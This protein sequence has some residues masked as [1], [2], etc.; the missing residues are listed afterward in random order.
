MKL[1]PYEK[2][3]I[4]SG[5][6]VAEVLQ[7]IKQHTG[8]KKIFNFRSSYEFSGHVNE[9]GF[10]ITK[11]I[12]YNNSFLPVI[13]GTVEQVSTGACVTISMRLYLVVICFMF[14]VYLVF[15]SNH[16]LYRGSYTP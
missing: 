16:W 4:D 11:N 10:K 3:Q 2:F 6:S 7:R 9:R 1:I 15:G 8:E 5:L 12:S 13:E 14:Y